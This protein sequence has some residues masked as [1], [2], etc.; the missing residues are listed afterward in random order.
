LSNK[1]PSLIHI[2]FGNIVNTDKIVAIVVPESAPAK[3]LIQQG[4]EKGIVVDVTHGR[5]TKSVIL[6]ENNQ[7]IL[8]AFTPETIALRAKSKEDKD[9]T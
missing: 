8:S 1:E 6:M 5:K 7:L 9:E 4:K 2:G 3:R